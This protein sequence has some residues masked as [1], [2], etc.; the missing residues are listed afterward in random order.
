VSTS[1]ETENPHLFAW[2]K[3]RRTE[4]KTPPQWIRA[5]QS[6]RLV[7]AL[8]FYA[9]PNT[10]KRING[11]RLIDQDQGARARHSMYEYV[12]LRRINDKVEETAK[13]RRRRRL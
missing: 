3:K 4:P 10:Y 7:D 8:N 2:L 5:L 13:V 1:R 6:I 9:D 12:R 11:V